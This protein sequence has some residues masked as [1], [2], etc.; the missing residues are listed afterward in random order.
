MQLYGVCPSVADDDIAV[1]RLG[2]T[3]LTVW[4]RSAFQRKY[5]TGAGGGLVHIAVQ[6]IQHL[7]TYFAERLIEFVELDSMIKV[8]GRYANGTHLLFEQVEG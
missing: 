2:E 1:F 8:D 5:G 3:R 7:T 4:K 6:S